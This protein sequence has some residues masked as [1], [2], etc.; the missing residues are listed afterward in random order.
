MEARA[1][2]PVSAERPGLLAS[3]FSADRP[4]TRFVLAAFL[5][6]VQ[7]AL[8]AHWEAGWV[9]AL[10]ELSARLAPPRSSR[11]LK[12]VKLANIPC[13]AATSVDHTFVLDNGNS[14]NTNTSRERNVGLTNRVIA[15]LLLH[16][17]RK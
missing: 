2:R 17:V 13:T 14:V 7:K 5:R 9:L 10:T 8:G 11:T 16:Q 12:A 15:G 1:P 4:T 6:S 3:P